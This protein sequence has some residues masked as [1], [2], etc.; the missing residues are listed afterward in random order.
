MHKAGW[1]TGAR[2]DNGVVAYYGGA[3]VATVMTWRTGKAD[4]LAGQVSLWALQRFGAP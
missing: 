4:E 2:H 3:Y 1:L